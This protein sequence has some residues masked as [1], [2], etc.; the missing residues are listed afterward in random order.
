MKPIKVEFQ[1]FGPY[2]NHETVD[3]EAL[4]SK[5]LFLICGKTGIGKTM[6]LDAMTFA[7]YGKSSG[8]GRD[9]FEALRCTKADFDA[10]TFVK[11]E[12]E[13]NG[14]RY[15]FERRLERKRKNLSA[16]YSLLCKAVGTNDWVTLLENPKEKLLNEKAAEIIGLEYEQFRQVMVLPQG[17]FERLLTSNSDEKEKILTSIFGETK[18]QEFAKNFY[19]E[20]EERLNNLKD[21]NR[22]INNS[23]LEEQCQSIPQLYE[24]IEG[25]KQEHLS[26]MRAFKEEA[27]DKVKKEQQELLAIAKR[28]EDLHK[29]EKQVAELD[30]K[31]P[32]Y[33][34]WKERHRD[35]K[36]AENV[37]P[38]IEKAKSAK[39][40]FTKRSGD[41]A[42][43]IKDVDIKK[44]NAKAASSQLNA[45]ADKEAEIEEKKTVIAQYKE[46][47]AYYE[48]IDEAK[49]NLSTKEG[50]LKKANIEEQAA[51]ER[52]ES[53]AGIIVK[54]R[55]EQL[56]LNGE[57]DAMM[58]SYLLGITG[59]LAGTL[60]E[61]EPCPVCGSREHPHKAHIADNNITKEAVDSKKVET[62]KKEKELREQMEIK[63]QA[64][65]DLEA[66]KNNTKSA[67]AE[68]AAA[69]A[70]LEGLNNNLVPGI[71]TL[72]DL[73]N[74]ITKLT[75]E[76]GAYSD[77]KKQLEEAEKKA[78]EAFTQAKTRVEA[79]KKE[80]QNAE[81]IYKEAEDE[82][83]KGLRDNQ[84]RSHEEAEGLMLSADG[85]DKLS[86]QIAEYEAAVKSAAETL[87]GLEEEL[88]G[89][90]EPDKEK[91]Q[92][93]LDNIN[94]A[95][96]DY[97]SKEA[98]L[99][100]EINRLQGKA[101]S[102]KVE[103]DGIKD[104]MI[105]AENDYSFAKTLRGDTGTGLQRYVLGIMFSSV[106]A[107][108]NKML[109]MVHG[110][111]Y[112][113]FRSDDKVQGSNKRGLELKVFDKNSEEHD[114]R[115]VN[116]LS[117]GEKF[118]VSL[119]LAI[120]MSTVAGKSG[121]RI[122]ALFIDE[123]F[124]TLDDD[125]IEDAIS[126]LDS[127]KEANGLV[128]I[129][130]HVQLLYDNIP[131]KLEVEAGEKGSRIVETVG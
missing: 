129:I 106:I 11:F 114:G 59:E 90:A 112:R 28:F 1:A 33:N 125:S 36:R 119:A 17:Q 122:N 109:E 39:E 71:S 57:Y 40:E 22:R 10:D 50:A 102:L 124:G 93:M 41:E 15:L 58:D 25:K 26:L 12:F 34:T 103:G 66:K 105:E 78:K 35:A 115:F 104:K 117:G 87:K 27:Y 76:I 18:W 128:G 38:L 97:S 16:H 116:T 120:G 101:D 86:K 77:V 4:S 30:D 131:V 51:K 37:R 63:E 70:Y 107:A 99:S 44:R 49:K 19:K 73:N 91:S 69:K 110:G 96:K 127:I 43:A 60:K 81:G 113:L 83:I 61:G 79:A 6:I 47:R 20:A 64:D 31:K 72:S 29:A 62:D 2:V 56:K 42:S 130:S 89:K 5:G 74:K 88:K 80:T 84:F 123:G 21:V 118:L 3:F 52:C 67:E 45:H 108:A 82:V 65:R 126:I 8:N 24:L 92:E 54:L 94:K 68:V 55:E 95:E 121:I 7:L 48:S 46:K 9:N 98:V 111:R 32:D 100:S 14:K 85:I 53:I 75:E 23:L 13:N